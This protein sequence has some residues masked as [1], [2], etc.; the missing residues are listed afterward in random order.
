VD[1]WTAGA[2]HAGMTTKDIGAGTRA[3]R[4]PHAVAGTALSFD[5]AAEAEVLMREP[6]WQAGHNAKTLVKHPD[7]RVVLIVL[8]AGA[9]MHEHSTDQCVTIHALSGHLRVHLPARTL[10]LTQGALLALEQTVVHDV[11][12]LADSVFVLSLGWSKAVGATRG[13]GG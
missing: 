3:A 9:R 4:E 2:H 10:D 7:F 11:E 1:E 13:T 5:L 6:T 8:K 12:A